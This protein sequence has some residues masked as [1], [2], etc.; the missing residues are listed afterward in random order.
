MKKIVVFVLIM[1]MALGC[2]ACGRG[3]EGDSSQKPSQP[4]SNI[5]QQESQKDETESNEPETN[6]PVK[7]QIAD[8]RE[9]LIKAWARYP[10]SERF[11]VVGGH[12]SNYVDGAPATYDISQK[13]DLEAVFCIPQED[14][15]MIDDAASL[16]HGM[17]VNNF[18]AIAYH[19]VEGAD[20][21]KL[22]DDIKTKTM[23]NQWLCGHPDRL[24]MITIGDEYLVT[25]YGNGEVI[26]NFKAK[27]LSL[28]DNAP[29]LVVDEEL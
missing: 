25:A 20:M 15:E 10:E 18:S 2:I 16:Q 29:K 23:N 28:Y 11:A 1:T 27:V 8:A 7:P 14:I 6:K 26:E 12:Y 3:N 21:Q 22:M 19:L 13:E 5:G 17:N 24:I 4:E 9:I